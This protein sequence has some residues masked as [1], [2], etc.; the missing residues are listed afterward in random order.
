M[1][2]AAAFIRTEV[3]FWAVRHAK[4][5]NRPRQGIY[6]RLAR[7]VSGIAIEVGL[8]VVLSIR[9]LGAEGLPEAKCVGYHTRKVFSGVVDLVERPRGCRDKTCTRKAFCSATGL[10]TAVVCF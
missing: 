7:F 10:R 3:R 4:M 8:K 6:P 1:Q 9:L 5:G 2:Y